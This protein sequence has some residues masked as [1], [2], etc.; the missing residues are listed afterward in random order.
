MV[1]ITVRDSE[2]SN[3]ESIK[4]STAKQDDSSLFV[5]F[6]AGLRGHKD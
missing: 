3:E 5:D 4:T 6:A 2:A 1:G